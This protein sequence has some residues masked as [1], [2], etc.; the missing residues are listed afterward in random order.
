MASNPPD[1]FQAI[2]LDI[3]MPIMDG[4]TA[5]LHIDKRLKQHPKRPFIYALTA[6]ASP[7]T[8]ELID[9][10]PFDSYFCKLDEQVE[11]KLI[12]E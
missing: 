11:I 12:K 7:E 6:D 5:C 9:K 2:I 3:N 8:Q 10:H 4:Y 1:Y